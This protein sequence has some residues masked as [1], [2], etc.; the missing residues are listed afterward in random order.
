MTATPDRPWGDV[1]S[2]D[3]EERYA[4]AGFGKPSG[5]GERP[6][7]LVI[8]VQYRTIGDSPKPFY[9]SLEDSRRPAARWAG[10]RSPTSSS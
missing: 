9:D 3:D 10:R 5:F 2:A 7:L 4:R 1:I 8:D 6:G